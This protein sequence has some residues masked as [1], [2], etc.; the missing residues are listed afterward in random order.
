MN[1]TALFI[2]H[3]H[4]V[5]VDFPTSRMVYPDEAVEHEQLADVIDLVKYAAEKGLVL[6]EVNLDTSTGSGNDKF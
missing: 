1:S 5:L 3:K 4:R 6:G 2:G